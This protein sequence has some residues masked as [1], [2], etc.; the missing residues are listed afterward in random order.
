VLLAG[1]VSRA[2][3]AELVAAG[4]GLRADVLLLPHH[5]SRGS[6]S[7]ELLAAVDPELAVASAPCGGRFGWPHPASV[8]RVRAARVSLWWTGRDGAVL[9]GLGRTLAAHGFGPAGARCAQGAA[10]SS[11]PLRAGGRSV[12]TRRRVRSRR[13]GRGTLERARRKPA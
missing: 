11:R 10:P 12:E 2:V 3:E 6:S 1:D 9:V 13:D 8:A 5:G 7:S 4:A